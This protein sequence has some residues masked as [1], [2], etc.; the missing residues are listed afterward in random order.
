MYTIRLLSSSLASSSSSPVG[1]VVVTIDDGQVH[2][3]FGRISTATISSWTARL[4]FTSPWRN[5]CTGYGRRDIWARAT[6]LFVYRYVRY[7]V[8]PQK[9]KG[10]ISSCP[11]C[12]LW[13]FETKK[14]G[15]IISH[16]QNAICLPH[17]N[18]RA[19]YVQLHNSDIK[20]WPIV[21][22]KD[23]KYIPTEVI[24]SATQSMTVCYV[25]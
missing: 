25:D 14:Q 23:T 24:I 13:Q 21:Y 8:N 6:S 2:C 5:I 17:M 18:T 4:R 10:F 9:N 22:S 20:L 15:S 3:F 7:C 16:T 12:L 11:T 1:N 19:L